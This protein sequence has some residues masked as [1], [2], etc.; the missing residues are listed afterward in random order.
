MA[1][2][3][4]TRT[5]RFSAAMREGERVMPLELFFD[6][7]FVLA[8]TQCTALMADNPTWSGLAEGMLVLAVLWWSWTGYT[9]LTS[10]VDP[11]EGAVRIAIFA[12][13]AA[14]LIVAICVPEAFDS[15]ALEFALA[16]GAVRG[17][18][19]RPVRAGQP[20]RPG[21]AQVG[22]RPGASAR[23]SASG[24]WSAPRSSTGSRRARC[25][26]SPCC[27]TWA[28]RTCSGQRAGSS[29]PATSPSAT[30]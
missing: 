9:W 7:V 5:P 2:A 16:Y 4:D 18:A 11:E 15:L 20:G 24:C 28:G 17:G 29:S 27:S 14:F 13:M 19:H 3:T 30:G 1:T 10:V 23:R 22:D 8:L 6:L 26:R 21:A 12:A 25:G